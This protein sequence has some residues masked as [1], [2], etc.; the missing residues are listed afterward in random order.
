MRINED[1]LDL[2]GID[3]SF[4]TEVDSTMEDDTFMNNEYAEVE[5][6]VAEPTKITDIDGSVVI[7]TPGDIVTIKSESLKRVGV[8][9]IKENIDE[10]K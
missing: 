10:E 8:K 9:T 4:D 6:E 5:M 7:V 3:D 2:D 1:D